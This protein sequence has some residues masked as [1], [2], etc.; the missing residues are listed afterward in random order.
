MISQ[1]PLL[2][3]ILLLTVGSSMMSSGFRLWWERGNLIPVILMWFGLLGW[4]W[5]LN[6]LNAQI[7]T[8][9]STH[10]ME[11]FLSVILFSTGV[12]LLFHLKFDPLFQQRASSP[13]HIWE[14]LH[15]TAFSMLGFALVIISALIVSP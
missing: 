5:G 10:G 13:Y 9:H 3:A 6:V 11:L 1:Y 15:P 12:P 14:A 7:L 8:F 4:S 2:S